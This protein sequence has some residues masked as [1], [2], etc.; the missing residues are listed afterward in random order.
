[1]ATIKKSI[2]IFLVSLLILAA[3]PFSASAVDIT[4][5]NFAQ[6]QSAVT[7]ASGPTNILVETNIVMSAAITVADGKDIS[8]KSTEGNN[9]TLLAD[10]AGFRHFSVSADAT[11]SLEA[12]TLAGGDNSLHS[13][14]V[15]GGVTNAGHLVL[16]G[17]AI[18]TSCYHPDSGGGV[19]N[20][21]GG[22]VTINGGKINANDSSYGS[23]IRNI[24]GTVVMRSGEINGNS[25]NNSGPYGGGIINE[26]GSVI[27]SGGEICGNS[28]LGI[29]SNGT[30]LFSG[31]KINNNTSNG[32]TNHGGGE[33][34]ISGGEIYDNFYSGVSNHGGSITLSG[35]IISGNA[36]DGIT[37]ERDS[38]SYPG[39]ITVTMSGGEISGNGQIGIRAS[40]NTIINMSDGIISNN[41]L[42]GVYIYGQAIL[43]ISGGKISGNTAEAKGDGGG[44]LNGNLV[45]ISGGEITDNFAG[46]DG[47]GIFN[48]DTGRIFIT[49]GK[50][51]GNTAGA[52]GGGIC[53]AG[54]ISVRDCEISGN[55]AGANGGGLWTEDL[56]STEVS[57]TVFSGNTASQA[58]WMDDTADIALYN[59][60]V[61]GVT[62]FSAPPAGNKPFEYAY[63][64]YDINYTKGPIENPGTGS[65]TVKFT[66]YDGT[67]LHEQTVAHGETA[68][69][70]GVPV[71]PG[72]HFIGWFTEGGTL[73]DFDTPV[74][75]QITLYAHWEAHDENETTTP[76]TCTEDGLRVVVCTVC[77]EELAREVL[78]APGHDLSSVT[79][80]PTCTEDGY[81]RTTCSR[82]DYEDVEVLPAL[83]HDW[84]EGEITTPPTPETEGVKT[85]TCKCCGE[86]MTMPI[87]NQDWVIT[88]KDDAYGTKIPSNAHSFAAGPGVVFYWDQKQK[89]GGVLEVSP[90]F[91]ETYASLTIVVKSGSEYR[92]MTISTSGAF[93]VPKWEDAKGNVHNINMVWIQFND[94]PV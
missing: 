27:I 52:S 44:I 78:N 24:G 56:A 70:P 21:T 11:L 9:F 48:F 46:N 2:C 72:F 39:D 58:Y 23:G 22:T 64:N 51:S 42:C 68:T 90:I 92:K 29:R 7:G 76:P 49:G 84:D 69:L 67:V 38:S 62:S 17:G 10:S 54:F 55:T 41:P 81:T 91:F 85:F 66:D 88:N 34:T 25:S 60:M 13:P 93:E 1:M 19:T 57:D 18:I 45:H 79:L 14:L 74:T 16:N 83:G 65:Y 33:V 15:H 36:G 73:W 53:N 71:R 20:Q 50:I 47:G 89:D 37:S 6:L 94:F 28:G 3:M 75:S 4:V 80:D 77:G 61:T 12:I 31:G 87:S 5:S 35:G 43:Y 40:Y 63:N 59:E 26:N 82:C 30:V 8:I 86:T 32:I